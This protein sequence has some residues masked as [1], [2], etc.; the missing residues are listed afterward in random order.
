[1]DE[2]D[3]EVRGLPPFLFGPL[4]LTSGVAQGFISVSL[5]YVL[6]QHG[7]SVAAIA[8]LVSLNLLPQ[9]WRF[10]FGPV[11]DMSLTAK[12][13]FVICNLVVVVGMAVIGFAPLTASA[14]P[15]LDVCGLVLGIA[16][17]AAAAS[18]AALVSQ[19]VPQA[20]RGAVAGWVQ[21]G[22]LGGVG[23]GGGAGLWLSVHAGGPIVSA[24]IL[25]AVCLA[26]LS[27]IVWVRAPRVT[28]SVA[29]P[30]QARG[31]AGGLWAL[32]R[33]RQG[34]LAALVVTIP[35]GLGAASNL[36]P[37]VAGDWKASADLVA[38]ITGVLGGL[39]SVPGCLVAGYLCDRFP[40]RVVYIWAALA[41]AAGEAAMAWAPHTPALFA[42]M[43]L[44]NGALVGMA[45]SGIAAIIFECLDPRAAATIGSL[46]GS[47]CNAP[48]VAMTALVG[49]VQTRHGSN[50]M[51]LTE[52]GTAVVVI[53]GYALLAYLWRPQSPQ[54]PAALMAAGV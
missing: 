38:L 35:A 8:G 10:V 7:V 14:M 31:L 15:L 28:A 30:A 1:M 13:W 32:L 52:A 44:V 50:A 5:G 53:A 39:A 18:N 3:V 47:L 6:R 21:T 27:P 23:L 16:L 42:I 24:L 11:V 26:S 34:V 41:C 48:V 29:L 33:T 54:F 4:S 46:L 37:V 2:R 49:V 22:N 9:T 12:R 19:I 25:A 43:V 45:F 20:R 51:L 36:F 40:R 17:A